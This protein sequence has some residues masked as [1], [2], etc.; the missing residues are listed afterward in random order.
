LETQNK[1]PFMIVLA[2]IGVTL[3]MLP[4]KEVIAQSLN[5]ET[6]TPSQ[7]IEAVNA[8]RINYG[9]PL[10]NAHPA[11]MQVA[12][13]Q[14]D[15]LA[16]TNGAIGHARPGGITLGQ[17]LIS[18]GYPLAGDLSL[19][20][21]RS[22]N[23]MFAPGATVHEVVNM[24]LGDAPHTNTMLSPN[25]SD[26][27]AGVATAQDEWMQTVYYFVID[28][29]LQTNN[30]QQQYD[31]QVMLTNIPS[32]QGVLN[33]D[34][35]Q[36][37]QSLQVSQYI[38]PVVRATARPIG[39]VIHEVKNGQSM[40][41]IAIEYGVKIDQIQRLNNLSSTDLY[42]GQKLLVQKG[43]TQPAPTPTATATVLNAFPSPTPMAEQPSP[44]A[45]AITVTTGPLTAT[46]TITTSPP[47]K[48]S[49]TGMVVGT[50]FL[51]LLL[52]GLFT[53]LA[54]QRSA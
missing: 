1:L 8:L 6:I 29:A 4:P 51:A 42:S 9:L 32:S 38:M 15:A 39:D 26:I 7:L 35:T 16:A 18:L 40:W 10:L 48:V 37:A 46:P 44:S 20:G 43:A 33:G 53:Y 31:A 34:S 50:I 25:R 22:E 30:G 27:G 28:T 5:Q 3:K 12:Q 2:L 13:S 24:W 36:A 14:A 17:Q 49:V 11:L 47:E 21:Y 52:A 45:S 19:E 41:S 23:F 54:A